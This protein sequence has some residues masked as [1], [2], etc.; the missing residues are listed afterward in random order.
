MLKWARPEYKSIHF[1]ISADNKMPVESASIDFVMINQVIHHLDGASLRNLMREC[2]RVLR[3]GGILYVNTSTVK[4]IE[5]AVWWTQYF[6]TVALARFTSRFS[7]SELRAAAAAF[8]LVDVVTQTESCQSGHLD[9]KCVFSEEFRNCDSMWSL[10]TEPELNRVLKSV[11]N[12]AHVERKIE[13]AEKKREE[14]GQTISF[15]FRAP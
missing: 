5:E 14:I 6:P 11:A 7:E 1:G 15:V 4:Q 8:K 9:P 2:A 10:L 12:D 13:A 3:P